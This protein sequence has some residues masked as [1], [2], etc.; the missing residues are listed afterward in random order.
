MWSLSQSVQV[1]D[2]EAE[3]NQKISPHHHLVGW[4]EA[5]VGDLGNRQLL[6]VSLFCGDDGRVGGQREV[7]ARVRHQV[8]LEL[9]QVN[10]ESP[11][12]SGEGRTCE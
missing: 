10:V 6:V 12:K 5:G 7:D 4:L 8:S 2:Q 11:V 3:T 1:S 9:S